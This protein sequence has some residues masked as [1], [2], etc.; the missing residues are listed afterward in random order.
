MA[1]TQ[2]SS[3]K[4]LKRLTKYDFD[5]NKSLAAD[6]SLADCLTRLVHSLG[7]Y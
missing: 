7:T 5:K 6:I 3:F 2:T 1:N 4:S